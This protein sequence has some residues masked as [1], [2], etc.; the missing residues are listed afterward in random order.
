MKRVLCVICLLLICGGN[1]VTSG[2]PKLKKWEGFRGLKWGI[3]IKD[4]ND[5]NMVL[6]FTSEDKRTTAYVR[7]ND[8]LSIGKA[9]LNL[10]GYFCYKE[11]F[12][13]LIVEAKG[14]LNF[15]PLKDAI[16]A[17]YGEGSQ[18]NEF[19]KRWLWPQACLK[20]K[21]VVSLKYNEFS[22]KT[23]FVMFYRPIYE[24]MKED[25]KKAAEDARDNF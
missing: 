22:E 3:N 14:W 1:L 12:Y 24:Q 18:P 8:K 16:F 15:D 2:K 5:P 7:R 4:M 20:W 23:E 17:Y 10:L 21:V 25:D 9:K 19:I 6:M 13:G 11:R